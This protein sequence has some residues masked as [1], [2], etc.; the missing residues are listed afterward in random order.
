MKEVRRIR[1]GEMVSG[2]KGVQKDF[3][4][5]CEA[6][7]EPAAFFQDEGDVVRRRSLCYDAGCRVLDEVEFLWKTIEKR[8]VGIDAGSDKTVD[9]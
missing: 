9:K 3:E 2:L 7:R 4:L 8:A 5:N 6:N 1:W